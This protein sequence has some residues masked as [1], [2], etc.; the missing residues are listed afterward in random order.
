M[1][2]FILKF[3]YSL[4]LYSLYLCIS[5]QQQD[6]LIQIK[7]NEI[8]VDSS[9][10]QDS[11]IINYS[12]PY[13]IHID[14]NL[15]SILAYAPRTC[16]KS[17]GTLNTAIGN[18][19]ADIVKEQTD[20]VFKSR[21]GNSISMVLLNFGGIRAPLVK[22]DITARTAYQIM[23]FE[24]SVVVVEMKG[25][26]IKKMLAY[27]C[28]AQIAHPISGLNLI[29]DDNFKL[30][31]ATIND[32]KIE[33][34]TTYYVATNDYLYNGGDGMDFFR[35]AGQV[36]YTNYK[37]RNAMIDY[38]KKEDTIAPVPDHRFIQNTES[39]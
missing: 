22:G 27:L 38:F 25:T 32:M 15:D 17:D 6:H 35:E 16:I 13:K 33:D 14:K 34:S 10:P 9:I 26:Q 12:T 23:P 11:T 28:K 18:L 36:H 5:C 19:M 1:M 8:E 39:Y 3:I 21:T 2:N 4:S 30:K 24:N 20:P 7:G 29:V 37:I 31:Q